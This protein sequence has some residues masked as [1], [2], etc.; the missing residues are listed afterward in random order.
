MADQT[1]QGKAPVEGRPETTRGAPVFAPATDIYE[2]KDG[3]VLSVEIPGADPQSVEAT[4][5]NRVLTIRARTRPAA[6]ESL[7]P[8]R[9]EYREGDYERAFTLS[10]TLDAERIQASLKDGVLRLLLPREAPHQARRIKVS[11]G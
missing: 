6:P 10:E 8:V 2:T 3:L 9:L 5:E 11:T 1:S 4:I 7:A